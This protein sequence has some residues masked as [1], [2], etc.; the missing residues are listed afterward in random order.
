MTYIMV[1]PPPR[2]D[3]ASEQP[4]QAERVPWRR[5]HFRGLYAEL[6]EDGQYALHS[7]RFSTP[8]R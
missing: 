5:G 2:C 4:L 6:G 1:T 7:V 8:T 3:L